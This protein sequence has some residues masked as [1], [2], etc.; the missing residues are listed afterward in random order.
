MI[1][2]SRT[3]GGI[4]TSSVNSTLDSWNSRSWMRWFFERI[5]RENKRKGSKKWSEESQGTVF[6]LIRSEERRVLLAEVIGEC[7]DKRNWRG[8]GE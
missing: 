7:G 5:E 2:K 3:R 8:G 6:V 4:G 1:I